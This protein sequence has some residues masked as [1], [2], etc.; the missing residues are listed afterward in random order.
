MTDAAE[1]ERAAFVDRYGGLYEHSP[2]VVARAWEAGLRETH[3]DDAFAAACADVLAAA[4]RDEQLALIRAHPDLAGRAATA[5]S[6]TAESSTEQSSAALDQCSSEEYEAFQSLNTRYW[7]RFDF[8]FVM[9]VRGSDRR[10]IL[11]RFR[12]R[13]NQPVDAEFAQALDE[14]NAIARLRL[15]AMQR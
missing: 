8:P 2:W 15:A 3:S 12:Q 5:G 13:I 9:A 11:E 7:E 4:T 14:I 6:L 10:S 1:A